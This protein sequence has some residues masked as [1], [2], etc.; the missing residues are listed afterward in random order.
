MGS[1][2]DEHKSNVIGLARTAK[3]MKMPVLVSSS[4]AQWQNGDTLPAIK[5]L[6]PEEPIYRRT[7]II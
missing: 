1:S 4:N 2:L 3:A 7:G 6:F 5:E